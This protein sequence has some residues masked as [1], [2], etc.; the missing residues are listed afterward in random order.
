MA[1]KPIKLRAKLSGDTVK[2][3]AILNHPMESGNRK[4]PEGN[5]IPAHFIQNV[6]CKMGDE[7]ILDADF[8]GGVS[9]NPYI[10]FEFTG[11]QKGE[12][13]VMSWLDNKGETA[14]A[15]GKIK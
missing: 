6:T 10:A 7:T 9:K 5:T 1:A 14:S 2:V 15:T 11:G 3:K 4:D 12:E 8:G 13:I